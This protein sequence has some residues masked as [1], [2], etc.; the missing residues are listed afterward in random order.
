[1]HDLTYPSIAVAFSMLPLSNLHRALCGVYYTSVPYR[2]SNDGPN[3]QIIICDSGLGLS[4]IR[5]VV[6]I[7]YSQ[8]NIVDNLDITIDTICYH[9]SHH[10]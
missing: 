8:A 4:N 2:I 3:N 7:C 5:N 1:M 9:D 6:V 10:V